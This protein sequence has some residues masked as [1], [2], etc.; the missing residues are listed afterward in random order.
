MTDKFVLEIHEVRKRLWAFFLADWLGRQIPTTWT[1][2]RK[3]VK[4]FQ[5][6]ENER[7]NLSTKC[8]G[9]TKQ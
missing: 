7:E 6:V 5:E 1:V 4:R 3:P 8:H 9:R 2:I